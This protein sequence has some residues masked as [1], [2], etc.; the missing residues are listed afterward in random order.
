MPD[1][2]V[3]PHQSERAETPHGYLDRVFIGLLREFPEFQSLDG[4]RW[5][6]TGARDKLTNSAADELDRLASELAAER[7]ANEEAQRALT[8]MGLDT[9]H[10]LRSAEAA[11]KE[12]QQALTLEQQNHKTTLLE[13]AHLQTAVEEAQREAKGWH[14]ALGHAL[15]EA[16]L[17]EQHAF[18]RAAGVCDEEGA[19]LDKLIENAERSGPSHPRYVRDATWYRWLG[20]STAY[21]N[22]AGLI[23]A[24][25][26]DT[27]QESK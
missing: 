13:V 4:S 2:P 11:L 26:Q 8:E 12:A 9:L 18:E 15:D 5:Y 22:A 24:L 20:S 23:R 19:G 10:K 6:K 7:A 25:S 17:I 1:K 3:V 16:K 14:I 27:T 21:K